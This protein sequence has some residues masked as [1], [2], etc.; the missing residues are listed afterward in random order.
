MHAIERPGLPGGER[1]Q[2][3]ASSQALGM[4][5]ATIYR[6]IKDHRIA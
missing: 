5:R 1:R 3:A 4:S 2:E 6:N